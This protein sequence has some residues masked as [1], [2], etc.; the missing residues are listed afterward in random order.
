[1]VREYAMGTGSS[2]LPAGDQSAAEATRQVLDREVSHL[3]DEAWRAAIAMIDAHRP[4]LDALA[5]R[6][7]SN[8]VLERD[9]IVQVMGDTPP[10]APR[11]IGELS[12]A[13]ATAMKPAPRPDR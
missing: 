12:V 8:E 3:A 7:L 11:R 4:Q 10:A 5:Q 9:D 6:L 1:M 2:S 13:A